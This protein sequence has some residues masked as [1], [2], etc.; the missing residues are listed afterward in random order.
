MSIRRVRTAPGL[1]EPVGAFSQATVANGLVFTSGQ[2]PARSDG[3]I[4]AD[5]ATQL[6]V[7]LGNLR[8]VLEAAGS[9]LDLVVKV[10]GYLTDREQLA[11]YN[12]TYRRWF[13]ELP[14]RTTVCVD[15]WGVALEIDCTAVVREADH[16]I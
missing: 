13:G 14:A 15:L 12:E 4:P 2:I 3:S 10:N 9:G 6:D 5:F 8:T 16:D 7:A 1:A 11:P